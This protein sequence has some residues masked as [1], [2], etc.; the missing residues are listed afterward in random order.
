MDS[1]CDQDKLLFSVRLSI[2][3]H[4]RRQRFMSN[5]LNFT[6]WWGLVMGSASMAAVL[7]E[8]PSP[9]WTVVPML[10]LTVLSAACLAYGI[11]ARFVLHDDLRR[12]FI[13]LEAKLRESRDDPDETARWGEL[14]R[15][16][17]E[18]DEPPILEV[19][20]C[21]CHNAESRAMGFPKEKQARVTWYQRWF[22]SF[23]DLRAHTIHLPPDNGPE[24]STA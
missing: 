6:L 4:E 23:L 2:R 18:A 17:I 13:A 14:E 1:Q 10:L 12:R 7:A 16:R 15:L 24:T 19:L 21:L 8:L 3:Y 22:S 5:I 9:F 20:A 11:R